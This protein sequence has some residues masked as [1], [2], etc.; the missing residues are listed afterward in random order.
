MLISSHDAI[1]LSRCADMI[2]NIITY[3]SVIEEQGGILRLQGAC[4]KE[5]LQDD[6]G[7]L[8]WHIRLPTDKSTRL[9]SPALFIHG[10]GI[11]AK[12]ILDLTSSLLNNG[13]PTVSVTIDGGGV[14]ESGSRSF[15]GV[16][17]LTIFSQS[18][19]ANDYS[20]HFAFSLSP[21][22]QRTD[23]VGRQ[24]LF[25]FMS[26]DQLYAGPYTKDGNIVL[27]AAIRRKAE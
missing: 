26:T 23:D 1:L 13:S 9:T 17:H 18:R 19:L 15:K 8:L 21:I 20:D 14:A 11:K 16:C 2:I 3:D 27:Y 6:D 4:I 10:S 24:G 25:G 5:L 22:D 7:H 12:L